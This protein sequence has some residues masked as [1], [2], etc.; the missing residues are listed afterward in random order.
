[1]VTLLIFLIS[2][3]L[4]ILEGNFKYFGIVLLSMNYKNIHL[5]WVASNKSLHQSQNKSNKLKKSF[6]GVN[7]EQKIAIKNIFLICQKH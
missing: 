2:I 4:P 5:N 3:S 6:F 7:L 1:M